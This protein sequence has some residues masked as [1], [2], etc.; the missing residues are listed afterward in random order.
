MEVIPLQDLINLVQQVHGATR[1]A[2][3]NTDL[4]VREFLG[5]EKALR[6]FRSAIVNNLEKTARTITNWHGD[7]GNN[8]PRSQ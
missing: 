5:I 1:V 3:T 7:G 2:T 6:R 8:T 4:Y